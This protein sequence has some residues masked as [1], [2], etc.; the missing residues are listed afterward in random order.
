MIDCRLGMNMN[1][2]I[3]QWLEILRAGHYGH[4]GNYTADDLDTIVRN[5][6]FNDQVPIVVGTPKTD[7]PAWGW[8]SNL[9]REGSVLYGKV[10][11]LHETLIAALKA[12][13]F[14]KISV[15]V[16]KRAGGPKLLHYGFVP[17]DDLELSGI[18]QSSFSFGSSAGISIKFSI[19]SQNCLQ[20]GRMA[21]LAYKI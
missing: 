12:D 17:R 19:D 2:Q 6:D 14:Q 9:K 15:G 13:R 18:F 3:G 21:D 10:G 8:I 4:K 5:F 7:S 20:A 11:S 16:L 1:I